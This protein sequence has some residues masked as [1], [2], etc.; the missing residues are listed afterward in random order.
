[1]SETRIFRAICG[2]PRALAVLL[3]AI[4][5]VAQLESILA[6][7]YCEDAAIAECTSEIGYTGIG[8]IAELEAEEN[9]P[10]TLAH[11]R[12]A[13]LWV[14]LAYQAR[15]RTNPLITDLADDDPEPD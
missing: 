8:A 6:A 12:S 1:M 10:D 2:R 13:R 9:D 3:F 5:A 4:L 7:T 14:E 15:R 11:R